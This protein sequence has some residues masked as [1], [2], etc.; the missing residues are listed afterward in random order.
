MHITHEVYWV[1][2]T[3]AHVKE[4]IQEVR[5]T[6]MNHAKARPVT[7][8]RLALRTR[9][10]FCACTQEGESERER[11]REREIERV[12][13]RERERK[14][15]REREWGWGRRN[16]VTVIATRP[17][18]RLINL[19]NVY[20]YTDA[21][22]D[23]HDVSVDLESFRIENPHDRLINEHPCDYPDD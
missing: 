21:S 22:C 14:R 23:Q 11:E 12:R 6:N 17:A 7:A 8:R 13:E 1:S 16:R 4:T 20:I 18:A 5:E 10:G 3:H 2:P 15:E 19:Q 9:D